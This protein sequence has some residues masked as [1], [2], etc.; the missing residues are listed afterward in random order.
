M[1][2]T[3]LAGDAVLDVGRLRER[4]CHDDDILKEVVRIFLN[5]CPGW[6]ESLRRAVR[7]RDVTRLRQ[8][9]H[10][11]G[12]TSGTCGAMRLS[13]LARRLEELGKRDD[14]EG[15]EALAEG[16]LAAAAELEPL[17]RELL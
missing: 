15:A 4:T 2:A 13:G 8:T 14:L 12:G 5:E 7:E 1:S 10:L 16:I 9:A 17:L 6:M 11:I 3:A